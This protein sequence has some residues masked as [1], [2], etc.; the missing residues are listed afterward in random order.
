MEKPRILNSA[1]KQESAMEY[2]FNA[3]VQAIISEELQP[4]DKLPTELELS[5]NLGVGR[6]TVREAV[7]ILEAYGV[8]TI[9]RPEGTFVCTSYSQK[10]LNPMI[11]GLLLRKSDWNTLAQLREVI[12]VGILCQAR[13]TATPQDLE[14]LRTLLEKL[15]DES[16]REKIS[17]DKLMEYD[18][19]FHLQLSNILENR[20]IIDLSDYI[21]RFTTTARR[22]TFERMIAEGNQAEFVAKHAMILSALESGN[23]DE[24]E[25]AAKG[26]YR[27]WSEPGKY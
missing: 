24:I 27:L 6:N 22:A 1:R 3:I 23:F 20:A 14:L 4:G 12:E 17:I 21:T 11:Y 13:H 9:Q 7:K 8:V 10:M 19:R 16:M 25:Q 18:E 5:Q 26:H 15:R 2:V